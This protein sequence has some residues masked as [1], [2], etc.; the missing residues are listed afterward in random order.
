M[1]QVMGVFGAPA[2]G[3]PSWTAHPI[4]GWTPNFIPKVCQEG[5][6]AKTHDEIILVDGKDAMDTALA[7]MRNEGIFCGTSG[8]ATLWT[9]LEAFGEIGSPCFHTSSFSEPFCTS[10]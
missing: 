2:K 8:G 9:A 6:D 7:L 5:I 4:Q 10:W 3:H 1:P